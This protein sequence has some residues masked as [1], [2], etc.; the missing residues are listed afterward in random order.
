MAIN[1]VNENIVLS[2]SDKRRLRKHKQSL[3]DL[4]GR[5]GVALKQSGAGF[6]SVLLPLVTSV[7]APLLHGKS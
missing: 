5:S 6:L 3:V 1:T 7:L 4:S 2:E